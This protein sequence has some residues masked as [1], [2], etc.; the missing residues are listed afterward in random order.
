VGVVVLEFF[1]DGT[2]DGGAGGFEELLVLVEAHAAKQLSSAFG[3]GSRRGH[4]DV[5]VGFSSEVCREV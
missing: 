4:P 2:G 5:V 1:G 3:D